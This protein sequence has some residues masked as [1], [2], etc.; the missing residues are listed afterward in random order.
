MNKLYKN[1][2]EKVKPTP[3][4]S[5]RMKKQILNH[6]LN[7]QGQTTLRYRRFPVGKTAAAVLLVVMILSTTV[8]ADEVK[9]I[10][11]GFLKN[12]DSTR[13]YTEENVFEDN[14]GHVK[15]Q[16]MELV[17]DEVSV[18]MTVKYEALDESGKQWLN[19]S[20][21]E[22]MD[23][24]QLSIQPD[25][26]GNTIKYGTNLGFSY[27]ELE[28]YKSSATRF[29]YV[30]CT[31]SNWNPS[32]CQGEFS[33]LLSDG[34]HTAT[35]NLSCNVP[36]YE[37]SLHAVNDQ[38]L[39]QYYEPTYIRLSPLSYVV[40]GKNQGLFS[41]TIRGDDEYSICKSLLSD[42]V[43]REE[44]IKKV[45]FLKED[46]THTDPVS[47]EFYLGDLATETV[48]AGN[49]YDCLVVSGELTNIDE[50]LWFNEKSA[51]IIDLENITGIKISNKNETVEYEFVK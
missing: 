21:I 23:S 43:S 38:K 41:K 24:E 45:C 26:Q 32:I 28:E 50:Q 22:N 48:N 37:Y 8:F 15:I 30:T 9:N 36:V 31:N 46:G 7:S 1:T 19:S 25:F 33:Y 14:D 5:E 17:S 40:Y 51:E 6:S 4:Q 18:Q 13:E 44:D 34:S 2:M 16:V 3:E 42:E 39:S 11:Q 49:G 47:V 35:L 27:T 29:Y 12:E 10:F 20:D